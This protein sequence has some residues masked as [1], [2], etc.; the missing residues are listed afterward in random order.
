[1]RYK[2]HKENIKDSYP[3]VCPLQLFPAGVI[4]SSDHKLRVCR[5][6]IRLFFL[7]FAGSLDQGRVG[8]RFPPSQLNKLEKVAIHERLSAARAPAVHRWSGVW[9]VKK[10]PRL[11]TFEIP[12]HH[13]HIAG[14]LLRF[15]GQ[16]MQF[17]QSIFHH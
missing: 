7:F 16:I 13:G 6:H 2:G 9:E 14:A 1:M 10:S 5:H 15:L 12:P 3:Q 8:E 11:F 17:F 4:S